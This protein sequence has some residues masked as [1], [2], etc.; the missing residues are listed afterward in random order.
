[1]GLLVQD[2]ET[3]TTS[4]I[5]IKSKKNSLVRKTQ[6]QTTIQFGE[7]IESEHYSKQWLMAFQ[8]FCYFYFVGRRILKLI[9]R[10]RHRFFI[11]FVK[12]M[13]RGYKEGANTK[14][15]FAY[16]LSACGDNLFS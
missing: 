13:Y 10:Q 6:D 1:M 11:N 8:G 9:Y 4:V 12:Y 5:K 16:F 7:P 2:H 15:V 3:A 14:I